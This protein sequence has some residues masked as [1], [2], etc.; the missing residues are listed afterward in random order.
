MASIVSAVA[1]VTLTASF[2]FA[3]PTPTDVEQQLANA[4]QQLEGVIE[5][6]DASQDEAKATTA[7]LK[8]IAAQLPPLQQAVAAAQA[9]AGEISSAMYRGGQ[10]GGFAALLSAPSPD[11]LMDQ[12]AVLD[13]IERT[14]HRDLAS[15]A[16][17]QQQ[18]LRR[19][20]E[21]RTLSTRETAQQTD[22]AKRRAAIEAQI[23]R[24]QKASGRAGRGAVRSPKGALHDGFVPVFTDDAAGAAVKFAYSQLGKAYKFATDGPDTYDCSGLVMAS[25]KA[26]GVALPHNALRQYKTVKPITRDQLVPGD[27]VFYYRDVHHVALYIGADRV[28]EA[29]QTGE[30]VSMR[31]INFAPIVGYGRPTY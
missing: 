8:T 29:P 4:W 14:R 27:L 1:A 3:D 22:L 19:Q 7:Q 26:A 30:K 18:V 20:A 25:W 23:D 16:A 9:R 28:I 2:G 24:L 10:V 13:H 21:L 5:K 11:T 12:L 31:P 17:D 15:L 6:Y